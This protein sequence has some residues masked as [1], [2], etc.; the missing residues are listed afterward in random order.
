MQKTKQWLTALYIVL[1][2]LLV[3]AAGVALFLWLTHAVSHLSA[4]RI[5]EG[6]RQLETSLYTAAATCYAAEGIYPPTLEYLEE[7]YGV[8]IDRDS[9][10]VIYHASTP[11]QMPEITVL[12]QKAQNRIKYKNGA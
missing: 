9:Y 11:G 8:S 2:G 1:Y 10:T 6:R 4:G 7:R 3:L 5:Q 12:E